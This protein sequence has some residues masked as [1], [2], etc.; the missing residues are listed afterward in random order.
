VLLEHD[1][2]MDHPTDEPHYCTDPAVLLVHVTGFNALMWD[3]GPLRWR[4]VEH[5]V[6][7]LLDIPWAGDTAQGLV[8]VNHL[9]QRGRRL[10][11]DVYREAAG[12]VPLRLVGMASLDLKADGGTGEVPQFELPALLAAHRFFFN[13]IR[14]TSLGLAVIEAMMA[15]LPVVGLATTE[16]VTV[17]HSGRNGYVDTRMPR[18][19]EVMRLL[20]RD[21]AQAAEWGA[22]GQRTA[23]ER[24]G[25]QRFVADWLSVFKDIA[26]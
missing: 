16:L 14:H 26:G 17:I 10:G 7:P 13:P 6:K 5:G 19:V 15:G 12:Q 8:V 3:N 18:L 24:F 2:P 9:L 11:V 4:V 22:A 21:K 25:I 20:L 23:R 1:P